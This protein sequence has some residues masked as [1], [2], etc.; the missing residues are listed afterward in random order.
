M[1]RGLSVHANPTHRNSDGY[2][3]S[4]ANREKFTG[5]QEYRFNSDSD[6]TTTTATPQCSTPIFSK[7]LAN[8][9]DNKSPLLKRVVT[10]NDSPK[11]PQQTVTNFASPLDNLKQEFLKGPENVGGSLASLDAH[12]VLAQNGFGSLDNVVDHRSPKLRLKPA[13]PGKRIKGIDFQKKFLKDSLDGLADPKTPLATAQ[14]VSEDSVTPSSP[15]R[16]PQIKRMSVPE[17]LR[18]KSQ[19]SVDSGGEDDI[20]NS[21]DSISK[22][23]VE[24]RRMQSADAAVSG[25][26][27][28]Y[29]K[30]YNIASIN[31]ARSSV[32]FQVSAKTKDVAVVK[33]PLKGIL[34]PV[35]VGI[36]FREAQ[37]PIPGSQN[38]SD[39]EGEGEL[40]AVRTSRV[41]WIKS[42]VSDIKT[43]RKGDAVSMKK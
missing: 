1:R 31:A 24:P 35:D 16:S 33:G 30:Q 11:Y 38:E 3:M 42:V 34:K 12:H 10:L 8:Q 37:P 41:T 39:S 19:D 36:P 9:D 20:L 7:K 5:V 2:E 15:L 18:R 13:I 40:N 23:V 27:S 29:A 32:P 22:I 26:L 25:P 17:A 28:E 14:F 4:D 43:F 6:V 21:T